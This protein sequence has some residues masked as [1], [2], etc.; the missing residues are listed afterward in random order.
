MVDTFRDLSANIPPD[1]F[2]NKHFGPPTVYF[3]WCFGK[4]DTRTAE[5]IRA[6]DGI[7]IEASGKVLET[8]TRLWKFARKCGLHWVRGSYGSL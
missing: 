3:R 7:K 8:A 2:L 6:V 5:I 1:F 4:L